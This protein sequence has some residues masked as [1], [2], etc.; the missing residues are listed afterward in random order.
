MVVAHVIALQTSGHTPF[1][2]RSEYHSALASLLPNPAPEAAYLYRE[3][4]GEP[5]V[6]WDPLAWQDTVARWLPLAQGHV[7]CVDQLIAFIKPL[8]AEDQARV[9]LPWVA[10]LV[11]AD[12][13]RVANRTYL[14]TSWLIELRQAVADASMTADWQRVVDALVVAGVSRLAPYSE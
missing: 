11:L 3:V 4:Q 13:S 12:P 2:G 5:I 14:L 7:A 9:G 6:W 10:N 8:P 1:A